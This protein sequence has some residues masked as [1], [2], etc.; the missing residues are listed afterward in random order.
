MNIS[1]GY[2]TE[3]WIEGVLCGGV[4]R[5]YSHDTPRADRHLDNF[6]MEKWREEMQNPG[7]GRQ[8]DSSEIGQLE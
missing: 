6:E 8:M 4:V 5:C 7:L 1:R 3:L 2:F